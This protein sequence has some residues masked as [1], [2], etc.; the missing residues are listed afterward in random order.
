[1]RMHEPASV[2]PHEKTPH[3]S[4]LQSFTS[5]PCPKD[6]VLAKSATNLEYD[7]DYL[8]H[9]QTGCPGCAIQPPDS[10]TQHSACPRVFGRSIPCLYHVDPA[11]PSFPCLHARHL[12][13]SPCTY[14]SVFSIL[15]I[16]VSFLDKVSFFRAKTPFTRGTCCIQLDRHVIYAGMAW[17]ME[18]VSQD[19]YH[20]CP[21]FL[22][23]RYPFVGRSSN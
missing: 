23:S 19:K 17:L 14:F 16:R 4:S 5:L 8:G 22:T 10:S 7:L 13:Q 21:E 20:L 12:T 9:E 15:Q 3:L 1:M 6:R 2:R 18:Q 11:F